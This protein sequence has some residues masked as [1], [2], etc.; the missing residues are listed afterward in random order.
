MTTKI[1]PTTDANEPKYGGWYCPHCDTQIFMASQSMVDE[2]L[3][4]HA[5]TQPTTMEEIKKFIAKVES[6]EL[7]RV[8]S[9]EGIEPI[10]YEVNP[11]KVAMELEK[12]IE[13]A[14][15][16]ERKRCSSCPFCQ[17]PT[18]IMCKIEKGE[19]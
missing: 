12:L 1:Q 7:R 6:G 3:K 18:N 10:V 8:Y 4:T 11:Q 2:H 15:Q 17:P 13:A 9:N 5:A 14:V 19:A 16:E